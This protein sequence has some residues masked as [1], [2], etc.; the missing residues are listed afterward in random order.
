MQDGN[1][2]RVEHRGDKKS[3]FKIKLPIHN[4]HGSRVEVGQYSWPFSAALPVR[5]GKVVSWV[6]HKWWRVLVGQAARA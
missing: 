2:S 3:F 5:C 6:A 1:E 4:F